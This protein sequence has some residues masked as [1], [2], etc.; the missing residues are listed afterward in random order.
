MECVR[1]PPEW[2][3]WVWHSGPAPDHF[4]ASIR[5]FKVGEERDVGAEERWVRVTCHAISR[6]TCPGVGPAA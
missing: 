6:V 1:E 3:L 5:L 4:V 2:F